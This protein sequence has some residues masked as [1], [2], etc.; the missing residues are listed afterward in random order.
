MFGASLLPRSVAGIL[1][2]SLGACATPQAQCIARETAEY[3]AVSKQIREL[4]ET[5]ARGYA[6]HRQSIPYTETRICR[7]KDKPA[8]ACPR[9]RF[10]TIETPVSVDM[11]DARKKLSRLKAHR[12]KIEPE[13]LASR[14][15]CIRAYPE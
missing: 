14:A 2:I 4:E 6:L 7:P 15:A 9:T 13:A 12:S 8:F 3:R 10:H 5:V 1:L 11:G